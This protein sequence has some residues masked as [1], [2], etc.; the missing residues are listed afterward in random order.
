[1]AKPVEAHGS[2]VIFASLWFL[3]WLLGLPAV[4]GLLILDFSRVGACMGRARRWQH[5][6]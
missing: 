6:L 2:V 5:K 1:M 4:E 3:H